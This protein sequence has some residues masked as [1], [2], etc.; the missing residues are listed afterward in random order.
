MQLLDAG[1]CW[2]PGA[3]QC[4]HGRSCTGTPFPTGPVWDEPL[5]DDSQSASAAD[6]LAARRAKRPCNPRCRKWRQE[7]TGTWT[8]AQSTE[9]KKRSGA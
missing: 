2:Q 9:V 5:A 4:P 7:A 3:R 1:Y 6:V 8:P